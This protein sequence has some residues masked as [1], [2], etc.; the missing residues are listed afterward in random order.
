MKNRKGFT[1]AELLIVV[2]IIAVLVAISIP[3]FTTQRKKAVIATNKANIRAAVAA[4][5]AQYYDKDFKTKQI[6][7]KLNC[8]Y[9]RYD[10]KAGTIENISKKGNSFADFNKIAMNDYSYTK[11]KNYEV[12][13]TIYVYV[14]ESDKSGSI[15][16][17]NIETAP[18]YNGDEVELY[19]GNN[20]FGRST[21]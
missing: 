4:A 13:D 3:I 21:Y 20:P 15:E 10:V 19:N 18:Y 17:I 7:N 2:A 1:L 12:C 16:S 5:A 8:Q 9:Y 11:A 6:A 14:G